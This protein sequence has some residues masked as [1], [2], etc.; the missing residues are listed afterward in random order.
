MLKIF[1]QDTIYRNVWPI[2][3]NLRTLA[4]TFIKNKKTREILPA[5]IN[6]FL[7]CRK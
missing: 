1:T 2:Y 4:K 6:D 5:K 7:L 3:P